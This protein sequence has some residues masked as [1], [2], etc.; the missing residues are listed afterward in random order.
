MDGEANWDLRARWRPAAKPPNIYEP[1]ADQAAWDALL[2]AKGLVI[3]PAHEAAFFAEKRPDYEWRDR[4]GKEEQE[5][6]WREI[7]ERQLENDRRV[8]RLSNELR[9]T[10]TATAVQVT[11]D[12]DISYIRSITIRFRYDEKGKD[13]LK[14]AGGK[15]DPDARTWTVVV[16]YGEFNTAERVRDAVFDM[17]ARMDQ[18]R[19]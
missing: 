14:A 4:R 9:G 6:R 13:A 3:D 17:R 8:T 18:R 10:D 15:W 12:S 16:G 19:R 2:Q 5:R 7:R 11:V 1:K